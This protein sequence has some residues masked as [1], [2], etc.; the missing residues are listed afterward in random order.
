MRNK[1]DI[2]KIFFQEKNKERDVKKLHCKNY[3][4]IYGWYTVQ[5]LMSPNNYENM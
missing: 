3:I 4:F 5:L 1:V 2:S